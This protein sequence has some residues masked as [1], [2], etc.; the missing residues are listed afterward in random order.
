ML[1]HKFPLAGCVVRRRGGAGQRSL[2]KAAW[3]LLLL[4]THCRKAP[5][6]WFHAVVVPTTELRHAVC[7]RVSAGTPVIF[8][9]DDGSFV[10][11]DK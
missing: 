8:H 4:P 1:V 7:L 2:M 11:R 10:R 9:N 6:W 3:V 5:W